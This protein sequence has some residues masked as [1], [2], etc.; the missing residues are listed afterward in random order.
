VAIA[1][2]GQPGEESD[3]RDPNNNLLEF[4]T[5]LPD[6]P[7]PDL[8]VLPWSDW[9]RRKGT[10]WLIQSYASCR[11]LIVGGSLDCSSG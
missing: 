3:F 9:I 11:S 2:D 10:D 6:E 8:G 4:I 5:M 1:W 7:R